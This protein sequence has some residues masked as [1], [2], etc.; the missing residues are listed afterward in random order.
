MTTTKTNIVSSKECK[1][2]AKQVNE[3]YV[4]IFQT[5]KIH[6][7][8]ILN[9]N[10][11]LK[12]TAKMQKK[13]PQFEAEA[14][15]FLAS[16]KMAC[17]AVKFMKPDK[18]SEDETLKLVDE[19]NCTIL[20]QE[21]NKILQ[22]FFAYFKGNEQQFFIGENK[23]DITIDGWVKANYGRPYDEVKKEAIWLAFF[24]IEEYHKQNEAMVKTF[25]LT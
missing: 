11:E 7:F 15:I 2:I 18:K 22:P 6:K 4:E 14:E 25:L 3:A 10:S 1:K 13:K 24:Y 20:E 8:V 23:I 21:I 17:N 9:F 5:I 12:K 16:L 19:N